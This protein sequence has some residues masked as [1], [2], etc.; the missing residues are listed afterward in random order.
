MA[1]VRRGIGKFRACVFN[2]AHQYIGCLTNSDE[3][4]DFRVQIK[5][6]RASGYYMI[7]YKTNGHQRITF[8]QN[9][10]L[11]DWPDE[12]NFFVDRSIILF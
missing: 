8:N 3:L 11:S 12:L 9:G 2:P 4:L 1:V 6:E 5:E 7:L 10:N